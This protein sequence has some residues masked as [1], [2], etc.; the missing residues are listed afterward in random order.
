MEPLRTTKKWK[1]NIADNFCKNP[2]AKYPFCSAAEKA[3]I[4]GATPRA[5]PGIDGNPHERFSFAPSFSE[6]FFENWGGPAHENFCR[7]LAL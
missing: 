3:T 4:L 7:N 1:S 5:I 6:R 2:F